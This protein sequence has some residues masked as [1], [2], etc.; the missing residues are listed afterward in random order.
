MKK[1]ALILILFSA[2]ALN[3]QWVKQNPLLPSKALLQFD[4]SDVNTG[5]AVGDTGRVMRTTNGG[6]FWSDVSLGTTTNFR[7]VQ[8]ADANTGYIAGDSGRVYKTVNAG[9]SWN[10]IPTGTDRNFFG[11]YFQDA[12]T[13]YVGGMSVI[14]KTTNGGSTWNTQFNNGAY[15]VTDLFFLNGQTGWA[16]LSA[17]DLLKTTNGGANWTDVGSS[18][19]SQICFIN[20]NTGFAFGYPPFSSGPL[21]KTVNGGASWSVQPQTGVNVMSMY[22]LNSNTGFGMGLNG[23]IHTTDAG[24]TWKSETANIILFH[25]SFENSSTGWA[26]SSTGNVI[27][28]TNAGAQWGNISQDISSELRTVKFFDANTG[29]ITGAGGTFAKSTNGGVTWLRKNAGTTRD[30][31]RFYFL[32]NLTGWVLAR[33]SNSLTM[34]MKTTDGGETWLSSTIN[35]T[36]GLANIHFADQNTGWVTGDSG[37]V[38][39]STNGGTSWSNQSISTPL[40]LFGIN[41]FSINKAFISAPAGGFYSTSNGGTN[42]VP[43]SGLANTRLSFSDVVNSSLAYVAGYDTLVRTTDAGATWSVIETKDMPSLSKVIDFVNPTTGYALLGSFAYRTTDA[44]QNWTGG[45]IEG[46]VDLY[47]VSFIDQ[48]TGWSAGA[49]G[50]L[51]KT[52]QGMTISVQPISTSIPK[53]FS[54]GQNYPN[55]FNPNTTINFDIPKNSFVE[56]KVFDVLGREVASLV[57]E[58]LAAG[59]YKT[60]WSAISQPSGIY[61]YRLK[62]GSYS[63]TRKMI[64]IK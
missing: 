55:P 50:Q 53:D 48:N 54:L 23:F 10:L 4:F 37:T 45:I 26:M 57:N 18:V 16:N 61:F 33:S 6:S 49:W 22:F 59:K 32:N 51:Y 62:A 58:Q 14:L 12:N 9:G 7:L 64:L 19:S 38:F 36:R 29:Y 21:Q 1:I 11:M 41:S 39:R 31:D 8:F 43:V 2:C 42:W 63:E 3:A 30:L 52:T 5:W 20:E 17:S 25:V 34:A 27:K 35:T 24:T 28:T 56:I 13:G 47:A 40:F 60:D 46:A 44:G 15:Y